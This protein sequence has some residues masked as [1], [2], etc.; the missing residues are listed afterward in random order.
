M[1]I[2]A[3]THN[4]P[5]PMHR[6]VHTHMYTQVYLYIHV[7]TT[8]CQCIYVFIMYVCIYTH[9]PSPT[10][11][12]SPLHTRHPVSPCE[13]IGCSRKQTV[14]GKQKCRSV[15][16]H[17]AASPC[18]NPRIHCLRTSL[19]WSANTPA[20]AH[21]HLCQIGTSPPNQINHYAGRRTDFWGQNRAIFSGELFSGREFLEQHYCPYNFVPINWLW[22]GYI[23]PRIRTFAE[24]RFHGLFSKKKRW[25]SGVFLRF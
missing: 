10:H 19:R 5:S 24:K 25:K 3:H 12:R 7:R 21:R 6:P 18:R 17:H 11:T 22:S 16:L 13:G 14:T 1:Y 9:S 15:Q 2:H 8:I 23:Y 20:A 4:A